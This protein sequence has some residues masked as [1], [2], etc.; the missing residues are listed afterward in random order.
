VFNSSTAVLRIGEGQAPTAT[1]FTVEVEPRGY[2]ETDF[3]GDIFGIW[4]AVNGQ[5][6]VSAQS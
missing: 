1:L 5:A 2:Y 4:T 3:D 6:N